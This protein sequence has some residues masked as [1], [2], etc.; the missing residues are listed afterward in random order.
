MMKFGSLIVDDSIRERV[1]Q[2]VK[3]MK[4]DLNYKYKV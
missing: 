3:K 1:N 4:D 2:T